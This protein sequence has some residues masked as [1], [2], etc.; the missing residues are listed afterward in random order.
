[1]YAD[2]IVPSFMMTPYNQKQGEKGG[3]QC[4]NGNGMQGTDSFASR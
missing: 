2:Q 1:M 3:I 4:G